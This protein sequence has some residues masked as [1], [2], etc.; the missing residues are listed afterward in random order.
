MQV[1]NGVNIFDKKEMNG[2]VIEN[3]VRMEDAIRRT[4]CA[5]YP[6]EY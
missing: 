3:L 1:G 5:F 4:I 2:L 6:L